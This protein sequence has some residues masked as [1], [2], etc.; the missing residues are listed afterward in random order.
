MQEVD[1]RI[2]A[3]RRGDVGDVRGHEHQ[4]AG[5]RDQPRDHGQAGF[6]GIVDVGAAERLVEHRQHRVMLVQGQCQGADPPHLG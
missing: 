2:V 1:T 3:Q 5:M 4:R 6:G